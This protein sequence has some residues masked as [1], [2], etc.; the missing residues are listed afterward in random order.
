MENT[1]TSW[2]LRG[3][4]NLDGRVDKEILRKLIYKWM[5]TGTLSYL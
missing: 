2:A 1:L 5:Y 4:E 3:A